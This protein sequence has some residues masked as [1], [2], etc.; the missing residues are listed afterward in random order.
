M[1]TVD[2]IRAVIANA[3]SWTGAA[4]RDSSAAAAFEADEAGYGRLR[5][6]RGAPVRPA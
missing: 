3:L 5:M 2:E 6:A 4:R 1:I